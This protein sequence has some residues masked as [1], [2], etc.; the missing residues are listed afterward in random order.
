MSLNESGSTII[1][2]R[3]IDVGLREDESEHPL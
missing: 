2:D 1:M 3:R